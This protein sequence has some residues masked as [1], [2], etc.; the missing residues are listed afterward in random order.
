[1]PTSVTPTVI[2]PVRKAFIIHDIEAP[3]ALSADLVTRL[4]HLLAH[5]EH[6][7]EVVGLCRGDAA[8]CRGCLLCLTKHPGS[9][10]S[11][12]TVGSLVQR[13]HVDPAESIT[14]FISPVVFGHPSSVIKNALD[15]GTGSHNVQ[16]V[17]GFGEDID[18]EEG[19][20]FVDMTMKHCG[21]ADIVHPG[22]V[23]AAMAFVTRSVDGN[24]S[25]CRALQERLCRCQ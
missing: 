2:R 14:V 6:G 13:M 16:V 11:K 19:S 22:M 25:I 24:D 3:S 23:A 4:V 12:D 7:V 9:C 15:R 1:M 17:V 18:P 5:V 21:A 20:T 10:V 8:P